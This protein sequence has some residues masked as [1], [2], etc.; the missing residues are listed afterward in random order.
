MLTSFFPYLIF[1]YPCRE[2]TIIPHEQ[3]HIEIN[4][5]TTNC[6]I[7]SFDNKIEGNIILKLAKSNSFTSLIYLYDNKEKI[8]FDSN[9]NEFIN[10]K[11]RYHIG[12]EFYKEKKIENLISQ[13]YYFIIY[14]P[15]FFFKDDL[16]IYND[17]FSENNYYEITDIKEN[18]LKE[19]NFKYDYTNDNPIIIHFKKENDE[20]KYLNYQILEKISNNI[21]SIA[22][23]KNNLEDTN[24]IDKND[25]SES[26]GNCIELKEKTDYYIKIIMKGEIDLLLR[27]LRTKV[28]KITPDD[29]FTKEVI[30]LSEFYFYIEKEL[31][32]EN[33]EYFN[34]FT[35]KLDSI[36]L[37]NLPFEILTSTCENN[38]EE[39]LLKCITNGETGQKSVLKRDIDIPYIYHI[40]YSFN[41]KDY[42]IIK[43]S[44]NKN[45]KQKQRLIIEASGGNELIDEKHEKIFANNKGYLYPVYLNISI[46]TINSDYNNN[47][48]RILFINTNTSSALKIFFNDNSFK[49]TDIDF[50]KGEYISIENF[51]YG[52]DFND[53][54]VQKLFERRKY[55]TIVIYCPWE[56][57]PITFQ[58]TFA[59]NNINNFKYII[60]DYRPI[61]SPI[62]INMTTP[63][64][65]YYFIGQY[66]YI[67]P[68]ILFN[69]L[70]Y[71]KIQAKY[72]Y[73]SIDQKISSILYNDDA[74]GYFFENW[75]PIQSK[76]DI[77]EVTCQSPSLSYMYFIDNQAININNIILEKGLQKYIFINNTNYY[78]INL[79]QNLKESKNVNIEVFLV[80]QV[81]KQ[82][83]DIIINN[84]EYSLN[85]TKENDILKINT[86]EEKFES[87]GIRGKGTPTL[88]KVKIGTEE[89]S[90][91]IAYVLKYE[92]DSKKMF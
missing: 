55:F 42:L 51:V 12:E 45:F 65:K 46:A 57:S 91:N 54:E 61:I 21:F 47:K 17:N 50:K 75:T 86:K 16:I 73:F 15:Y 18:D 38:S 27:F 82:A 56:S 68:N 89:N 8:Q 22:L 2:I 24:I 35:V 25:N 3:N 92:K 80:S 7:F 37:K 11:N 39:E 30:S 64:D 34:E 85:K 90:K 40:Y 69:E 60:N 66:N 41:N 78:N 28:L 67:S 13:E 20:I 62:T 83:I 70:I 19:L 5:N 52:F 77:I 31:I 4:K 59:N 44:N 48:N 71:G 53:K 49:D 33:D 14:E 81:Q 43:I 76:I 84:Q 32:F 6:V 58:L 23:Y 29:I 9:I 1:S 74:P 88:I 36:N 26:F 10:Y 63:N 79:D 72:K 87:F